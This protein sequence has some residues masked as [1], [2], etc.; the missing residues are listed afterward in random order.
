MAAMTCI[1]SAIRIAKGS[2]RME[3]DVGYRA[4][5]NV[6]LME[7]AVGYRQVWFHAMKQA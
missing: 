2:L 7:N 3:V 1:C 6:H 5:P 4:G